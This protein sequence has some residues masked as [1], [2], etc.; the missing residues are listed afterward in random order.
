MACDPSKQDTLKVRCREVAKWASAYL[1]EHMHDSGKIA[2]HLTACA[3]C[4]AYLDQIATV[5]QALRTLPSVA[6]GLEQR[7]RL[8]QAFAARYQSH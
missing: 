2:L 3:G 5:R 1:D 6:L 7:K 8:R 4:S